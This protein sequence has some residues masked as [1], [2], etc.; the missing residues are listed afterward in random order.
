M[1][2]VNNVQVSIL[3]AQVH[4][5]A[6]LSAQV[7][8]TEVRANSAGLLFDVFPLQETS[9]TAEDWDFLMQKQFDLL[10]VG[11]PCWL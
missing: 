11:K 5:I 1:H 3:S 4:R 6:W 8:N 7:P 2:I 9:S 10:Q